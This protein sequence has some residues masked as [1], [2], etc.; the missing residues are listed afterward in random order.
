MPLL[1]LGRRRDNEEMENKVRARVRA[2]R[3]KE[4]REAERETWRFPDRCHFC[5]FLHQKPSGN[6]KIE[7]EEEDETR[8]KG[9]NSIKECEATQVDTLVDD[10]CWNVSV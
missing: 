2:A 5:R 3:E 7:K 9:K 8:K 10:I 1:V 6:E 4:R